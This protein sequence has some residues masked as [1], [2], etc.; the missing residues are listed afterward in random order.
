MLLV[1]GDLYDTVNPSTATQGRLYG[2]LASLLRDVPGLQIV[3]TGGNHDSAARLEL[4]CPLLDSA[5]ITIIGAVP[6]KFGTPYPADQQAGNGTLSK[7][8]EAAWGEWQKV[9][10]PGSADALTRCQAFGKTVDCIRIRERAPKAGK[11]EPASEPT[12]EPAPETET[13]NPFA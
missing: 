2:F 10:E 13:A 5:R 12:A 4:P 3:L 11:A 8:A 1:T 7:E 9:K 6:R